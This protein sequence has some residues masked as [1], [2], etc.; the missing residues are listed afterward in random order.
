MDELRGPSTSRTERTT[1]GGGGG[2]GGCGCWRRPSAVHP[3]DAADG[4]KALAGH[5]DDASRSSGIDAQDEL[6]TLLSNVS[7]LTARHERG[8]AR[9]LDSQPCRWSLRFR[10][11]DIERHFRAAAVSSGR[12]AVSRRLLRY[13]AA[14]LFVG[15]FDDVLASLSSVGDEQQGPLLLAKVLA[16]AGM[17]AGFGAYALY[18]RTDAFAAAP[19]AA[20]LGFASCLALWYCAMAALTADTGYC[21]VLVIPLLYSHAVLFVHVCGFSLALLAGFEVIAFRLSKADETFA[22]SSNVMLHGVIYSAALFFLFIKYLTE[23]Q[24]RVQFKLSEVM[25]L[26]QELQV[27]GK[28]LSEKLVANVLPTSISTRLKDRKSTVAEAYTDVSVLFATV[29]GLDSAGRGAQDMSEVRKI[30]LLHSLFSRF[31]HL[32]GLHGCEK[33]K[34]IRNCYMVAS[35]CPVSTELHAEQLADLALQMVNAV[36]NLS[37][38]LG[39]ELSLT[40]GINSGPVV[41]GVIGQKKYCYDL[42]GDAVN[43]ASRLMSTG[44]QGKIHVST[45]TKVRLQGLERYGFESRGMV[46][47]KGKGQL[48]VYFM[49]AAEGKELPRTNSRVFSSEV[50][51]KWKAQAPLVVAA[52]RLDKDQV[53]SVLQPMSLMF[54]DESVEAEFQSYQWVTERQSLQVTLGCTSVFLLIFVVIWNASAFSRIDDSILTSTAANCRSTPTDEASMCRIRL[55]QTIIT[56]HSTMS[57]IMLGTLVW[58]T[59]GDPKHS[60]TAVCCM[61]IGIGL[62]ITIM[63]IATDSLGYD[64]YLE[65]SYVMPAMVF[66]FFFCNVSFWNAAKLCWSWLV[67]HMVYRSI[68][69]GPSAIFGSD[70]SSIGSPV[71]LLCVTAMLTSMSHNFETNVRTSYW[72]KLRSQEQ[73]ELLTAERAKSDELL[74]NCLPSVIVDRIKEYGQSGRTFE[75]YSDATVL[76]MDIVSFTNLSSQM[77][78]NE[79]VTMLNELISGLDERLDGYPVEKIKTIGDCYVLVSGMPER[80]A[81]HAEAV[82]E[83]ALDILEVLSSQNHRRLR[84]GKTALAVRIGI[85]TGVVV[86]GIIGNKKLCYDVWGEGVDGAARMEHDGVP[87]QIQV[88]E[89]TYAQLSDK[90]TLEARDERA[91]AAPK[92]YFLKGRYKRKGAHS[93]LHCLA[94]HHM[95]PPC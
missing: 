51:R 95:L 13:L 44:V 90:Y 86:A 89:S 62:A 78:S 20:Q 66:V 6:V 55:A 70:S 27:Y 37:K 5:G 71:Y 30:A 65:T 69:S 60:Q 91:A 12:P 17:V 53:A 54:R 40:V 94:A 10:D 87:G 82:A 23:S 76:F 72:M 14:F 75:R 93:L 56:G 7:G 41:A 19:T 45:S 25:Q 32:T 1:V 4:G 81:N 28:M 48:M 85:H 36:S 11:A 8:I 31:D 68:Q 29:H 26:R 38:K 43:V 24:S 88:S 59:R 46:D 22:S 33:I 16:Y 77:D 9:L 61:A 80:R 18:S 73:S 35:G 47:V 34:T 67:F 74:E 58:T 50:K 79:L 92:T 49:I 84:Q 15:A 57:V 2:G 39:V 42:W 21:A 83:F 3:L 64:Q 63:N 52:M